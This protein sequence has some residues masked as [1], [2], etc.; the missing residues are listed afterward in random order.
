MWMK[1]MVLLAVLL[2]AATAT[3]Q[4]LEETLAEPG[5]RLHA[6][7]GVS[8]DS[9]YIWRG[10]DVFDGKSAVHFLADLNL[11][12]TGFGVSAVG[13]R[14]ATSG[15]DERERWDLTG[16]YQGSLFPG[17]SLATNFR[18]GYVYYA[19]PGRNRGESLDM[20]EGQLVLA[21]PNILP[22]PGLQPSY[23][24]IRMW[25][26]HDDGRLPDD[27]GGWMHIGMLDYAFS[28]PGIIPQIPHHIITLHAEVVYNGGVTITPARPERNWTTV[29]PNP[30]HDFTHAVFGA[31]TDFV[32]GAEG[33]L[34]FT[35]AVYY[36]ITLN[37]TI[38]EDDREF[39][40]SL[41]L[42]YLF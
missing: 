42:K 34:I 36:Q 37:N 40:V 9:K 17:E 3:A 41:G 22:I 16:Y 14:A 24:L 15:L 5:G 7:V 33:N 1:C 4:E 13:H 8:W 31:S 35:P 28:V 26:V 2:T 19:Y 32:F 21:W 30:D 11:F 6:M 12:E 38:N 18:V 29:Y 25:P 20:H 27:A 23:V 10:F 39:W